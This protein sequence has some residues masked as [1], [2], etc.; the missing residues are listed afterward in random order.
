MSFSF[1]FKDGPFFHQNAILP[2]LSLIISTYN[3]SSL[4]EVA[5]KEKMRFLLLPWLTD[6]F[7]SMRDFLSI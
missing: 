1:I 5:V 2:V 7:L 4:F 6:Q 3:T